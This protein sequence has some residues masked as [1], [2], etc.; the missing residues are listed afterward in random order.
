MSDVQPTPEPKEAKRFAWARH[1]ILKLPAWAWIAIAVVA[2]V[3]ASS[4][5]G[6]EADESTG[7]PDATSAPEASSTATTESPTTTSRPTTV[8]P[9][10][11]TTTTTEPEIEVIDSGTY[12][13]GTEVAPGLYRVAGYWALLDDEFDIIENDGVYDN[14]LGLMVVPESGAKYVEIS[15]EAVSLEQAPSLPVL[16]AGYTEGTYLVN[17]DIEPGTYRVSDSDYAYAARLSPMPDGS[18]DIIDN[19]G[20]EGN[21]IIKI[22]PSDFAFEFSGVLERIE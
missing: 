18:W 4:A 8:A 21:V 13:V 15:G 16:L 7:S 5:G 3:G 2:I 9:A 20:N 14:G 17:V 12:I 11:T 19:D 22:A 6:G 1:R 10:R